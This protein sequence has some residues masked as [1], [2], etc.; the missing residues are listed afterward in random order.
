MVEGLGWAGFYLCTFFIALPGLALLWMQRA[1]IT[2][3]AA[4]TEPSGP[5]ANV[6]SGP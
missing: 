1:N 2:A 4:S 5:A 3:M 6:P